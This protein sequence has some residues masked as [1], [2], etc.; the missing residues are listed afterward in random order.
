MRCTHPRTGGSNPSLSA[1]AKSSG[2]KTEANRLPFLVVQVREY[3]E[4]V[5]KYSPCLCKQEKEVLQASPFL[6]TGFELQNG[7]FGT[8]VGITERSEV[9]P[10]PH[11]EGVINTLHEPLSSF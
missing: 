8:K 7:A 1:E 2:L 3:W 6:I 11:I 4:L 10:T 5:H 9:I